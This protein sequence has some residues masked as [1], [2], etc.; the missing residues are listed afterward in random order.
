MRM[1]TCRNA[2]VIATILTSLCLCGTLYGFQYSFTLFFS[3]EA[4]QFGGVTSILQMR[5]L[6]PNIYS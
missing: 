1:D 6:K 5:K 3:L 4:T 2:T